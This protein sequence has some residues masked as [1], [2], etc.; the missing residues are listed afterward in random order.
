MRS[1]NLTLGLLTCC[2]LG[3][4]S[5]TKLDRRDSAPPTDGTINTR[6]ALTRWDLEVL[7]TIDASKTTTNCV[8]YGVDRW[9]VELTGAATLTHKQPCTTIPWTSE[10]AFHDIK[11]GV[12]TIKI[13]AVDS[14][15]VVLAAVTRPN[16]HV[17]GALTQF[18]LDFK[19]ADFSPA[20]GHTLNVYWNL[21]GTVDG[22]PKGQSWDTCVEVGAVSAEVE[23]D[24]KATTH[25]CDAGGNQS[26]AVALAAKPGAVRVRLVDAAGAALTTWTPMTPGPTA[27]PGKTDTWEY[28]AEFYWDAFSAKK[29][30]DYWFSTTYE[31]KTCSQL[32]P[33][34]QHQV[35]L[36]TLGG[37][38]ITADV[39]LPSGA[40]V[41]TNGADLG[42]CYS[43]SQAQKIKSVGWGEY[44][45][46]LSGA[47]GTSPGVNICWEKEFDIL[48]GAGSVNP[49]LDHDVPRILS[50]GACT[51]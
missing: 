6:D 41:K 9:R 31:G 3:C 28:V 5:S 50:T 18:V 19:A 23:V 12:Y 36:L 43:A 2:A 49:T 20:G 26:A 11:P 10:A 16:S 38:A 22:T 34:V 44:K 24:G 27:V 48:V 21:N 47:T 7:W 8:K 30:G 25:S 39:C 15:G 33:P 13:E 32:T 40:C 45:L 17:A 42:V 46:K 1:L 37:T 4:G 14:N 51:P 35:T 29:S